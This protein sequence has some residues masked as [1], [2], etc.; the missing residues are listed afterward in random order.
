M[1]PLRVAL[2][3]ALVVGVVGAGASLATASGPACPTWT[4][5]AGDAGP[6]TGLV[7]LGDK[8]LDIVGAEIASSATAFL[9]RVRVVK[10]GAAGPNTTTG[11]SDQFTVQITVDGTAGELTAK[12]DA[13]TGA[14]QVY[15][16]IGPLLVDAT[17][18]YDLTSGTVTITTTPEKMA[19]A[20]GK[21][22]AGATVVPVKALTAAGTQEFGLVAHDEAASPPGTALKSHCTSP[23]AAPV[24]T[25]SATP[26]P[27][28]SASPTPSASP[29]PSPTPTRTATQLGL[30]SP[31]RVTYSDPLRI[32]ATL[33]SSTGAALAGKTITADFTSS[34]ASGRTAS[35][36]RVPLAL[37]ALS[38]AAF[39]N[40]TT[41]WAGDT[42]FAP[43]ARSVRVEIVREKVVLGITAGTVDGRRVAILTG[44]DDD[45]A[46]IRGGAVVTVYINGTRR[47][48]AR[49]DSNGRATCPAPRG[50]T[51]RVTYPGAT[52]TYLPASASKQV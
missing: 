31:T 19:I 13:V 27:S 44:R 25:G 10:L 21:P 48:T 49:L 3:T 51:V 40:A 34:R 32:I 37:S 43:A 4:D 16:S 45:G 29:S 33:Q 17:A 1:T 14:K 46:L 52:G 7:P 2:A 38:S 35:D 11:T 36:G 15:A 28:A 5:P 22:I 47:G 12:R 18:E 39:Y 6:A 24:P 9:A 23:V 26:T 41:R 8:D 42:T 20:A 30:S 50:S